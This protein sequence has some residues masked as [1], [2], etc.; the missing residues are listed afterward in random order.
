METCPG[1]R[2][3]TVSL[4]DPSPLI[5]GGVL[6]FL[7]SSKLGS[8]RSKSDRPLLSHE[9]LGE[10]FH[11]SEAEFSSS[12]YFSEVSWR[13]DQLPWRPFMMVKRPRGS[14][15]AAS[16]PPRCPRVSTG[17]PHLSHHLRVFDDNILC[18]FLQLCQPASAFRYKS[19]PTTP[20]GSLTEGGNVLPRGR[21]SQG[22]ASVDR[23]GLGE[24]KEVW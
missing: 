4:P 8:R 23:Q 20:S 1:E 5:F 16:E 19:F 11:S 7:R 10:S 12:F 13:L 15:S 21:D 6:F 22:D 2:K 14:P 3:P 9:A 24:G 18:C 17:L